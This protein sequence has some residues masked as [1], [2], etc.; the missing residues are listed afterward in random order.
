M[1]IR[2]FVCYSATPETGVRGDGWI[3]VTRDRPIETGADIQDLEGEISLTEPRS[4]DIR[5]TGWQRFETA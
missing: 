3:D 4:K 2:Y 5:V 1:S